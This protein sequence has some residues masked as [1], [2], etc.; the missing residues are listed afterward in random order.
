MH[1]R[2]LFRRLAGV[3]MTAAVAAGLMLAMSAP[4]HA[5][6]A[7]TVFVVIKAGPL[8][9]STMSIH[10][11]STQNNEQVVLQQSVNHSKGQWEPI[12]AGPGVWGAVQFKNR[13]SHQCLKPLTFFSGAPVVQAVCDINAPDQW[14]IEVD[15]PTLPASRFL[16]ALT[17][18]YLT[19]SNSSFVAG[20]RIVQSVDQPGYIAQNWTTA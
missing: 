13:Y 20:T 14:W 1:Q 5:T 6:P 2:H 16:N 7:P 10:V 19:A 8:P 9:Q 18:N 12:P 11:T 4:G 3:T 15:D 17:F